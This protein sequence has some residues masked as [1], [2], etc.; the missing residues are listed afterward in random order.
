MALTRSTL[1]WH[2]G[3][4]AAGGLAVF[5]AMASQQVD[6]Y[7]I[8]N[9]MNKIVAD[10]TALLAALAPIA[11]IFGAAYRTW[12]AKQVPAAALVVDVGSPSKAVTDAEH[13][14]GN[15]ATVETINGTA[16]GKIVGALLI[17]LIVL[18]A[19]SSAYAAPP[20]FPGFSIKKPQAVVDDIKAKIT[21]FEQVTIADLTA[22]K[23]IF[24]AA[25]NTNG[26]ACAS[27][28][29]ALA[30][31]NATANTTAADDQHL[32]SFLA[33]AYNLHV[34]LQSGAP[35]RTACA[36]MKDDLNNGLL[37][38]SGGAAAVTK[39]VPALAMFGL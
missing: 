26:S 3:S 30:Q 15:S 7:A 35:L 32:F 6:V 18:T 1:M 37:G 24:D 28:W 16:A 9:D 4:M 27:A 20:T 2:A 12:D 33:K 21:Q 8:W 29:L 19:A 36:A 17:G 39:L 34:A 10:V 14:P 5:T 38:I 23:Q 11:A 13:P 25:K 22:A 31:A